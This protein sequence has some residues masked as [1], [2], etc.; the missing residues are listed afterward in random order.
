MDVKSNIELILVE[1]LIL[2]VKIV[3][4]REGNQWLS[5]FYF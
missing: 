2:S 5:S 1:G 3:N 4:L